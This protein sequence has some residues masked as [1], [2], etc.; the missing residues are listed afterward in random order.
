MDENLTYSNSEFVDML[1]VYG[2]SGENAS[3]AAQ[4]YAERFP[5]RRPPNRKTFV[6][7]IQRARDTGTLHP[8]QGRDGGPGRPLRRF[9]Q[10]QR[11]LDVIEENPYVSTRRIAE[12]P[13]IDLSQASIWRTI[14]ENELTPFH[15]QKVQDLRPE[16]F[17]NRL[18]FCHWL[19]RQSRLYPGF[20]RDILVCDESHFTRDGIMNAHNMHYW[21]RENPHVIRRTNFQR[22]FTVNVWAGLLNDSLIGPF[23]LPNRLNGDTYLNFLRNELPILLEDVPLDVRQRMWLLHD[24]CPAHFSR[25]VREHLNQIFQNRWIGRGGPVSWPARSPDLTP[26]DFFVWGYMKNLIY[27]ENPQE[28]QS[29][30]DLRNRIEEAAARIRAQQN[31]LHRLHVSWVRRAEL[32][33]ETGGGHFEH[34]L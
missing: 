7:L 20:T 30:Q 3:E 9:N 17:P 29:E 10:E 26:L 18:N 12:R 13:G 11:I 27:V 8:H 6:R 24:G 34:L 31:L 23:I 16:D 5:L 2:A 4:M 1:L 25:P 22:T 21:S 15:I 19:I 14:H 33:V 32:C 28:I